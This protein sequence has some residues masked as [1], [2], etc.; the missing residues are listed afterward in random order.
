MKTQ[1][2]K[3]IQLRKKLVFRKKVINLLNEHFEQQW[4]KTSGIPTCLTISTPAGN[5]ND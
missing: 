3:T 4:V 2:E 1:N 5:C